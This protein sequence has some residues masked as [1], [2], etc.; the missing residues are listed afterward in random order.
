MALIDRLTY[1]DDTYGTV[2]R[3]PCIKHTCIIVFSI[4]DDDK[5]RGLIEQSIFN[6]VIKI[7]ITNFMD[8]S[9]KIT[10]KCAFY[11]KNNVLKIQTCYQLIKI[12]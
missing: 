6:Y 3:A 10:M 1:V 8:I 9:Q 2:L 5:F 4:T 7:F 12:N 11:L